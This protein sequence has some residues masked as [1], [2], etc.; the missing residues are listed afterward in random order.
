MR[1]LFVTQATAELLAR[2]PACTAFESAGSAA[3]KGKSLEQLD[4]LPLLWQSERADPV[5]SRGWTNSAAQV[6]G[7]GA[8][9]AAKKEHDSSEAICTETLC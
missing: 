5:S 9:R 4:C 6:S 2:V 7:E 1:Y 8:L 3:S